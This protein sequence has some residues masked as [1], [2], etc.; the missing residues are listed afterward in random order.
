MSSLLSQEY[1]KRRI[2]F[3]MR[4]NDIRALRNDNAHKA[5]LYS[6]ETAVIE[7][8]AC[9]ESDLPSKALRNIIDSDIVRPNSILIQSPFS[10]DH[11]VELHKATESFAIEKMHHFSE[12]CKLLGATFVETEQVEIESNGKKSVFILKGKME[13]IEGETRVNQDSSSGLTRKLRISTSMSG[14]KPNIEKAKEFLHQKQLFGD[15]AMKSLIELVS[16]E[17]NKILEQRVSISLSA[18]AKSALNLLAKLSVPAQFSISGEYKSSVERAEQYL[19]TF[20]VKF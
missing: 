12:L 13:V 10:K 2:V 19:L 14:G 11:Y 5:L 8:P 17:E 1:F 4:N 15:I 7:Y 9:L 20:H 16:G 3:V 18:E 6:D